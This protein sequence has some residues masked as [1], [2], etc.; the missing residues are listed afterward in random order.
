LWRRISKIMSS[1]IHLC[2]CVVGM[3]LIHLCLGIG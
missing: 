3:R 2:M 1:R